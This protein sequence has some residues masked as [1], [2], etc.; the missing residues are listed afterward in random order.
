MEDLWARPRSFVSP[1]FLHGTIRKG[2]SLT[3][4]ISILEGDIG[5]E[6]Y[7]DDIV[8]SS[9]VQDQSRVCVDG[10]SYFLVGASDPS[11]NCQ[12]TSEMGGHCDGFQ[13]LPGMD[14]LDGSLWGGITKED[15]VN[16]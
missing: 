10:K 16:G 13:V 7:L 2:L 4:C 12:D 8:L 9:S 6:E 3:R 11:K 15:I 1:H 5:C 14:Q